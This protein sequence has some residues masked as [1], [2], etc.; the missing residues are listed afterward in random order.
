MLELFKDNIKWFF[1][2]S[3]KQQ[4]EIILLAIISVGG[5]AYNKQNSELNQERNE[6][7]N[8]SV[9]YRVRL[10]SVNSYHKK[11][12]AE[13]QKQYEEQIR[14]ELERVRKDYYELFKKTD[15]EVNR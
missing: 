8:D 13:C 5:Y 14:N 10:D 3:R 1:T 15:K 7:H 4:I 11:A 6:R 12:M 2:F 9:V